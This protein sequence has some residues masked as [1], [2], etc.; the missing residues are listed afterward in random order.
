M[1]AGSVAWCAARGSSDPE[2]GVRTV[3]KDFRISCPCCGVVMYVNRMTGKV[4]R[5]ENAAAEV[6]QDLGD[7]FD[8]LAEKPQRQ[9]EAF[10]SA[11]ENE[12]NREGA[13][14]DAFRKA[15]KKAQ[16]ASDDQPPSI[17]DEP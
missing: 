17:F 11:M 1:S 10:G 14:E 8:R 6:P 2:E 7:A 16:D 13:L 15:Q 9:E 4:D 12:R 3:A 5:Y